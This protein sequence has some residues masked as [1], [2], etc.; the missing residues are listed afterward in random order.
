MNLQP[1]KISI[2]KNVL[3]LMRL[4]VINCT[5]TFKKKKPRLCLDHNHD[6]TLIVNK[7]TKRKKK[8]FY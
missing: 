7:H 6:N 5:S 8:S 4:T 2:L 3:T 1:I